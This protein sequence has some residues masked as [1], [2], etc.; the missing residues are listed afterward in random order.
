MTTYILTGE[1]YRFETDCTI[2]NMLLDDGIE[3]YASLEALD[4]A[5]IEQGYLDADELCEPWS[6][7]ASHIFDDRGMI[8]GDVESSIE[9]EINNFEL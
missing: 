1:S 4:A 5:T 7:T 3:L 8:C 2:N 6:I 9:S